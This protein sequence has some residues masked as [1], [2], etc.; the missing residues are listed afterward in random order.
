MGYTTYMFMVLLFTVLCCKWNI[1]RLLGI[2]SFDLCRCGRACGIPR[3][4]PYIFFFQAEDGI[5]Y[6]SVTGVQ[7][8]ALPIYGT[9]Q[10]GVQ[11]EKDT[12][13]YQV[14]RNGPT[15]ERNRGHVA[16]GQAGHSSRIAMRPEPDCEIADRE[17]LHA[18]D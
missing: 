9:A 14:A 8:C 6:W 3:K 17:K 2:C 16:I 12:G 4:C 18:V 15:E 1:F 11:S 5:R 7:T 13:V 10:P